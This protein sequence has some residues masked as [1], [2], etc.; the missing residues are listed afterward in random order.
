MG[1]AFR[2]ISYKHVKMEYNYPFQ[3]DST[4]AESLSID[5]IITMY[6][7]MVFGFLAQ[8]NHHYTMA[9]FFYLLFHLTTLVSLSSY[10]Q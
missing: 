4:K 3:S 5:L 2:I 8:P 10:H 7:Y 6:H 1:F 9:I